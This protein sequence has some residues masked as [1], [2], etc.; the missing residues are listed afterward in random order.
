MP[1]PGEAIAGAF[2]VGE[3]GLA[4]LSVFPRELVVFRAKRSLLRK[5]KV[6]DEAA[7][8]RPRP[9]IRSAAVDKAGALEIDF[10]DG[11]SW[12]FEVGSDQLTGA[13]QIVAELA[14]SGPA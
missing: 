8:S 14:A 12:Q 6:T 2:V 5:P 1:Q 4:Y 9:E 13:Q 11:S 7:A 10:A 3:D